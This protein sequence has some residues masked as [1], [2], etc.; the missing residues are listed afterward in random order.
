MLGLLATSQRLAGVVPG[1]LACRAPERIQEVVLGALG[2]SEWVRSQ[3]FFKGSGLISFYLSRQIH[4]LI[5][6]TLSSVISSIFLRFFLS[7][8]KFKTK[9]NLM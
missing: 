7:S 9:L 5:F 1:V 2:M 8:P 6:L 4:Q 3:M